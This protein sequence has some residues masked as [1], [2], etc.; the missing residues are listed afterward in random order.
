MI[1]L[2]SDRFDL[3][4]ED[5]IQSDSVASKETAPLERFFRELGTLGDRNRTLSDVWRRVL[6]S[7]NPGKPRLR[8]VLKLHFKFIDESQ[9]NL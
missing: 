3:S 5:R 7:Q 8:S 4:P 9:Q 6:Q 1:I 2:D